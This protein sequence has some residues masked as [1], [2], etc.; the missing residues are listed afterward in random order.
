MPGMARRAAL[1]SLPISALAVTGAAAAATVVV[2]VIV[3]PCSG[4]CVDVTTRAGGEFVADP[5]ALPT[6]T[7]TL[8]ST[9][10]LPPGGSGGGLS[11]L[12]SSVGSLPTSVTTLGTGTR[13]EGFTPPPSG[14]GSTAAPPTIRV[15]APVLIDGAVTRSPQGRFLDASGATDQLPPTYQA[16]VTGLST[17]RLQHGCTDSL[18]WDDRLRAAAAAHLPAAQSGVTHISADGRTAQD[19]AIAAGYPGVVVE[20]VANGTDDAGQL[21]SSLA[22]GSADSDLVKCSLK[23]VGAATAGGVWVIVLGDR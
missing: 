19:R 18:V 14:G 7:S 4:D 5:S 23:S 9:L 8:G 6:G 15:T 16:L 1:I 21:V 10:G 2:V 17:L 3:S 11:T 22:Q 13:V 20:V 12:P